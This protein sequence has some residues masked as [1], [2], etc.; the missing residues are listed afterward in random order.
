[1]FS[2]EVRS[3]VA[4]ALACALAWV[5]NFVLEIC[6]EGDEENG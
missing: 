1:M 4:W 5:L 3:E 2:R 6:S